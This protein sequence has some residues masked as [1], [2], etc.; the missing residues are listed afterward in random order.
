[1]DHS[2]GKEFLTAP[3]LELRP[4]DLPDSSQQLYRLSYP[5]VLIYNIG[6]KMIQAV[7]FV[8]QRPYARRYTPRYV[9]NS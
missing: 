3:G 5:D 4:L 6:G 8:F 9:L 1:V 7:G 2:F